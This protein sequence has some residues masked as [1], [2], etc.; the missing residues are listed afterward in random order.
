[1]T[2][3]LPLSSVAAA[4]AV[5][6]VV[7]AVA[8]AVVVVVAAAAEP[9][10]VSAV[11]SVYVAELLRQLHWPLLLSLLPM[12]LH[13]PELHQGLC[14]TLLYCLVELFR[15]KAKNLDKIMK[16]TPATYSRDMYTVCKLFSL[17]LLITIYNVLW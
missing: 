10:L 5:V 4:A 17:L 15:N 6:V 14:L 8:A 7:A 1:M 13:W 2:R 16:L 9:G 12:M 3:P 11:L